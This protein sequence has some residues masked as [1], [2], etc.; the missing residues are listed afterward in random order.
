MV[1]IADQ[2]NCVFGHLLSQGV[3]LRLPKFLRHRIRGRQ[4]VAELNPAF[5]FAI[6]IR[7]TLASICLRNLAGLYCLYKTVIGAVKI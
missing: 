3:A 5:A 7:R 2:R 4:L 6:R 1:V